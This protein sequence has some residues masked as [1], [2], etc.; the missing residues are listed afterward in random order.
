MMIRNGE[1]MANYIP[2]LLLTVVSIGVLISIFISTKDLS[3][4][5]HYFFIAGLA[6][7]FEYIILI[8]LD[9]YT[10]KPHLLS[11]VVYDSILGDLSS[12]AFAV[13]AAAILVT[14]YQVRLKGILSLVILFI[15]IEE[16]FIYLNIYDH[17]WWRTYYTGIFLFLTFVLVKS[18]YGLILHFTFIRFV[19][20]YFSLVFFLSNGILV[21]F[22]AI[23]DFYFQVG[24][25]E[26]SFRDN[27]AYSTLLILCKSLFLVLAVYIRRYS[28]IG[29]L[30]VFTLFDYYL[31]KIGTLHVPNGYIYPILFVITL[32]SY[33][34]IIATNNI[35]IKK[36]NKN[37]I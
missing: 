2:Y 11:I 30:L 6:Y 19:A 37:V 31:V 26:N 23:P 7:V 27:I 5:T 20:L 8:L 4:L 14:A 3:Y 15:G 1:K 16:L 17:N 13:P 36:L 32:S 22:L 18:F 33:F 21:L 28:V 24:W 9:S 25:F 10:Y 12:Q 34:F 29:F 35:W